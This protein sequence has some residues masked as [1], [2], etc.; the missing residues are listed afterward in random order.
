MDKLANLRL[1]EEKYFQQKSRINW[2]VTG[3]QNTSYFHM[4]AHARAAYNAIH[5]LCGA[6]EI[7]IDMPDGMGNL[8]VDHFKAI[9]GPHFQYRSHISYHEVLEYLPIHVL[10]WMQQP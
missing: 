2:L 5:T 10:L 1:V 3:D 6:D 7:P 9:L 8:A 4:V